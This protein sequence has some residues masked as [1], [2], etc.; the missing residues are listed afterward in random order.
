NLD[1]EARM[2]LAISHLR[3]NPDQSIRQTARTFDLPR[4]TLQHR[5]NG[6]Q[7]SQQS[8]QAQ[9]KLSVFE[10][11]SLIKWINTM[12]GWGWPPKIQHLESMA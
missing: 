8:S 2:A 5:L 12:A 11:N 10:E 1:L 3:T 4:S 9:Q 6:R 7:S